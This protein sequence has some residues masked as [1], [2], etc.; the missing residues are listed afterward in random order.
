MF[1]LFLPFYNRCSVILFSCPPPPYFSWLLLINQ[2]FYYYSTLYHWLCVCA[3]ISS[4]LEILPTLFSKDKYMWLF[5]VNIRELHSRTLL[6][7][8]LRPLFWE[9]QWKAHTNNNK[10][11]V[12]VWQ[13]GDDI[14]R[15]QKSF[16]RSVLHSLP[17]PLSIRRTDYS[18][19]KLCG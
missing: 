12:C 10:E 2:A 4:G 7:G 14:H 6:I 8:K 5:L 13:G 3:L 18:S 11:C 15:N 19:Y 1:I 17:S 16:Y 9:I